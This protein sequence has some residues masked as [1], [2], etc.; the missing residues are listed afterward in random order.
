VRTDSSDRVKGTG[1]VGVDGVPPQV[2]RR[3]GR[4]CRPPHP[5]IRAQDVDPAEAFDN[6]IDKGIDLR[7]ISNVDR[8]NQAI[9]PGRLDNGLGHAMVSPS[10]HAVGNELILEVDV[11][12]GNRCTRFRESP[13]MSLSLPSTSA[14]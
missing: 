14:R 1:E 5:S 2:V 12:D 13:S 7:R 4:C 11:A 10:G 8:L 6:S 3:F 9:S